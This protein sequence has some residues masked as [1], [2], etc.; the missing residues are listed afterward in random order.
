MQVTVVALNLSI[1]TVATVYL[2]MLPVAQ[3]IFVGWWDYSL[4][5]N[6]REF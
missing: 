4:I 5:I 6:W 3:A 2:M 1:F